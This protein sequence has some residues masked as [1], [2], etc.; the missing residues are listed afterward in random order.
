MLNSQVSHPIL[1]KAVRLQVL[2][3]SPASFYLRLNKRI[4]ERLPS[5]VRNLYPVRS[6]G[7]WL[8]TLVC[9]RAR[10]EQ[11][12]RHVFSTESAGS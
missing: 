1:A 10:R 12:L 3:K 11:Y 6:Y 8:H 7:S 4:W 2:G 9:L 5:G